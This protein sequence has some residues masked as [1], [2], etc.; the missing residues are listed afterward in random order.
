MTLCQHLLHPRSGIPTD[1][2]EDGETR[3]RLTV[4][5]SSQVGCPMRCTFCAT[6][7]GGFARNLQPHE[8]I[9]QVLTVQE[10]FGKRVSNIVFMGMGEPLLNLK[11]VT[12][13]CHYIQE[14][15]GLSARS[16]TIST[17]GVPNAISKLAQEDT[18]KATLAVSIHA[19]NQE[20]R[21]K[22][23]PSA[24]AFPLSA[25]MAEIKGFY[26][27]TGRRV[28]FEYTLLKDVNDQDSHAKE[29]CTLLK[30]N[31]LLSHINVIPLNPISDSSFE[32]PSNNRAF[33]FKQVCED[34]GLATT[35]RM[36]RGT[37]A[38]AAC[39]QL[40]NSFQKTAVP[41]PKKLN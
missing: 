41:D 12:A 31:D 33:A 8:I 9:D 30:Q 4:C 25:L 36:T 24:K 22:I 15:I 21:E 11:N 18:I 35:I 29:L 40:R 27:A 1:E 13:A 37:E 34:M 39:G 7:K 16:I 2:S 26:K 32:R 6:G 3:G 38:N 19:P 14:V 28:T 5:V 23:I 10:K 20:L 17:V